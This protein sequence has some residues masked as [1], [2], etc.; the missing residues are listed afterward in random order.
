MIFWGHVIV[1]Q[2]STLESQTN[3]G[4]PRVKKTP[5]LASLGQEKFTDLSFT[6][7]PHLKCVNFILGLPTMKELNMS[8]QPSNVLVLIGD[9]PFSC[10][11]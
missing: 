9:I 3:K 8:I 11:S 4:F 10:E 7:L 6:F 1:P 5:T 2:K